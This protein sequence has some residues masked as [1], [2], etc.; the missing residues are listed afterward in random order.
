V[1]TQVKA[2]VELA[3]KEEGGA[4]GGG[5]ERS[6][7]NSRRCSAEYPLGQKGRWCIREILEEQLTFMAEEEV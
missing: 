2:P 6:G 7:C 3:N 4:R 5:E 1:E